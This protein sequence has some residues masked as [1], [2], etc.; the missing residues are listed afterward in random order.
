M[1][2]M[3]AFGLDRKLVFAT[4]RCEISAFMKPFKRSVAD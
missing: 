3:A 2:V 4:F 1:P